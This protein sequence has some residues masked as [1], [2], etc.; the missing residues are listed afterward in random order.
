MTLSIQQQP[1]ANTVTVAGLVHDQLEQ[2]EQEFGISFMIAMDQSEYIVDA[3]RGMGRNAIIG[4]I[5]AVTVLY[6]FLG[7]ILLTS[8]ITI[9][10]P[11][12]II[13]TFTLLYF[14]G[15]TLNIIT[16]V[17]LARELHGTD[18]PQYEMAEEELALA[19]LE[20]MEAEIG[21]GRSP[22]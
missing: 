10:I 1:D 12:S 9:A 7:N 20:Q 2:L 14:Q 4:A 11:V 8:I 13:G 17:G 3:V 22:F 6:M 16:I 21:P 18:Y 5:L 19:R 15:E